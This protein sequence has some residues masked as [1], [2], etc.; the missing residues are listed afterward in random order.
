MS[1]LTEL[2]NLIN[3]EMEIVEQRPLSSLT[4]DKCYIIKKL[5]VINSRF[6][7]VVLA[8]LYDESS[9]TVFKSYLPKRVT[10]YLNGD[11]VDKINSSEQ[12]KYTLTYLGQ[13]TPAFVGGKPRS[14][15]KFDLLC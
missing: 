1:T 11:I 8:H 2:N 10:E 3:R 12:I 9:N 6:G 7:K 14:L 15:I 13:N 4:V 5:M